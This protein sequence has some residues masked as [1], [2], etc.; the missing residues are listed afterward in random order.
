MIKKFIKNNRIAILIFFIA[1]AVRVIGVYPGYTSDHPDEPGSY[2]TAIH[3][4]YNFLMPGRFDYPAGMPFFHLLIYVIFI[5]PFVFLNLLFL[6][7]DVIFAFFSQG[8]NFFSQYQEAIFGERNVNALYW[9][10]YISAAV[11]VGAVVLTYLTAKKLFGK[12]A[13]IFAAFFLTFNFRHVLASHFGLPDIHSSFFNILTLFASVLLFEKNTRGRYLFAGIAAGLALSMKY[14]PFAYLPFFVVH[15]LWAIKKR[16]FWY[17]FCKDFILSILVSFVAFIIINPYYLFNIENVMIRN[18]QDYIRYGMGQLWLR[19]YQFFYLFHWGIGQLPSMAIILGIISMLFLKFRKF[20]IIFS[21]VSAFF[22][23]MT[24]YSSAYT[25][26]FTAV[27]P[28]L[29]IFAGFFVDIVYR[30]LLKINIRIGTILIFAIILIINFTSIR[31]AIVLDINFSKEWNLVALGD[32]LDKHLPQDTKVRKYDLSITPQALLSLKNKNIQFKE[33]DYSG[34]PN[35]LA[36]FQ[37]E[38]TQFAI[39]D[40]YTFYFMNY[41]WSG[42]KDYTR[43]FKYDNVPFDYAQDSYFGLTIK[44]LM[45]YTVYEIYQPWQ[46]QTLKNYLVF[47]IPKKQK[48]LGKNIAAFNFD[49]G[50]EGWRA[51]NPFGFPDLSGGWVKDIGNKSSGSLSIGSAG[52]TTQR[53]VSNP[54]VIK[55]GM[56]YTVKGFIRFEKGY[57]MQDQDGFIRLDTYNNLNMAKS[58]RMG[59]AVAVSTRAFENGEWMAV[60]GSIIAPQDAKYLVISYQRKN[61]GTTENY[62]DNVELFEAENIS[63]EPFRE[64]PYI[65]PTIPPGSIYYISFL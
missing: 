8:F 30:G 48:E 52:D 59:D 4:F 6:H 60:E 49:K 64:V 18:R 33:W 38:G 40:T 35:S 62:V 10:R 39:L 21:F 50:D 22:F 46:A 25:R 36:E 29:M 3:M 14:Q 37:E 54:I 28:Y 2:R 1:L 17:I 5:L 7:P 15:F 13:G 58:G 61:S 63:T 27:M 24:Y 19:G 47:K 20:L 57:S 23:V 43:Y 9:S 44:E 34:G 41:W 53:I 12:T 11:G 42:W 65:N 26:N 51:I 56:L 16:S 55:P 32:W 45:R 31:N